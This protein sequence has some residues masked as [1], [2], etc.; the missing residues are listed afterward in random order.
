MERALIWIMVGGIAC[1][2]GAGCTAVGAAGTAEP[3]H[4]V[5]VGHSTPDTQYY[6]K[7]TK[8]M[9]R[10]GHNGTALGI[11]W[12]RKDGGTLGVAT[13]AGTNSSLNWRTF[14]K[15]PITDDM[16]EGAIADLAGVRSDHFTSNVI[17]I[18]P[19]PGGPAFAGY[20]NTMDWF[21]DEWWR[22]ICH[23]ARQIARVAK[24]G[25]CLGIM[26][27]T[28]QYGYHMWNYDQYKSKTY[29]EVLAQARQRGR[30][31]ARALSS[32]FP[33]ITVWTFWAWSEEVVQSDNA[34]KEGKQPP[35]LLLGAFYDGML[36]GSTD[37]FVLVDGLERAYYWTTKEE[38]E[39]G[40]DLVRRR[41]LA[42][43]AVPELYREKVRV[44]F[45]L[46]LD[47]R[48][49]A[50]YRWN[51]EDWEKNYWTPGRLQRAIYWALRV[52]DGYVWTWSEK[53]VWWVEG[54]RGKP[55]APAKMPTENHSGVPLI[56]WDAVRQAFHS[57]GNDRTVPVD[58]DDVDDADPRIARYIRFERPA[59]EDVYKPVPIPDRFV[60]IAELPADGWLFRTDP[61]DEGVGEDWNLPSTPTEGWRE[62][63][64]GEWYEKQGVDYDGTAWYRRD[65]NVPALPEG[66]RIDLFFG[67]VDESI[68]C[69]I[70]G[71]L[72][73]W[74]DG[75]PT[76][77]NVPF[78]LDVTGKLPSSATCT[79]VFR[80]LDVGRM[81]GIW[82]T[83][84]IVA[85][86]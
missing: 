57:P 3:F 27:D 37:A 84:T 72:V 23:N 80:T 77:W 44:G 75:A 73:A 66:K 54:P 81:G 64:I 85:E 83:V 78:A 61:F 68:W 29:P 45:G 51:R 82:K 46:Y 47:A 22:I 15:E 43:S 8:D 42:R 71:E 40:A 48:S 41:A 65:V 13:R 20:P 7:N 30:E 11:A 59:E 86:K 32:V 5:E 76:I 6:A 28:E 10:R 63:K 39:K 53:P 34:K 36:E 1:L 62:I 16:I 19:T 31:Y 67:A 4:V 14:I 50:H 58:D 56:Y 52:G 12:P 60:E 49:W 25:R 35:Q 79:I 69:Y 18:F 55:P 33:D 2:L 17:P 9:E 24:E 70:N 21:D 74:H 26:F 38:F